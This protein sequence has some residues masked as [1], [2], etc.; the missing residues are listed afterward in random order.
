MG[1]DVLAQAQRRIGSDGYRN[2]P[3]VHRLQLLRKRSSE[4]RRLDRSSVPGREEAVC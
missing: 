2:R 1:A 3:F 4:Q